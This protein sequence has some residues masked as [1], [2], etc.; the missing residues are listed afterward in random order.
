MTLQARVD[1]RFIH[2]KFR[3]PITPAIASVVLKAW[4]E[5]VRRSCLWHD[6][7]NRA[8]RARNKQ[9]EDWNALSEQESENVWNAIV[10]KWDI[11]EQ[12]VKFGQHAAAILL[13][14][15]F[16]SVM[17]RQVRKLEGVRADR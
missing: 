17:E 1:E 8:A 10:F 5:G 14:D 12:S 16:V 9:P 11:L 15:T 2:D 7:L 3:M 4:P 13:R 6:A